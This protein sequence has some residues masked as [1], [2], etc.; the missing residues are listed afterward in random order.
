MWPPCGYIKYMRKLSGEKRTAIL[1][2]LVEG[3]SI[4]ATARMCGVSKLTILRLLADVGSLCR[5]LH[6]VMVRGLRSKRIQADEIWAFCG[7]KQK[8]KESGK[9]GHGDVW[10]WI[11]MDAETKIVVAYLVGKRDAACANDFML[12]V[13]GRVLQHLQLTTDGH[14]TYLNAVENA[15]G[16]EVDYAQLVKMYGS[17]SGPEGPER[18]Y[19][20][21]QCNGARK[22]PQLGLPEAKH[23]STSYVERQNLTVRMGNRRHTRLTNAFSKKLSNHEHAIALHYFHYNFIRRHKTL[24]TTPAVASGISNREWTIA[25][26]VGLLEAE[27][28]ENHG[29]GRINRADRT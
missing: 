7:C 21:G 15:F 25:D 28:R 1:A 10:T 26:L 13:A 8:N 2:A 6:N 4:N 5:K 11:A 19:S 12:D 24:G 18:K 27:E 14:K 22:V 16:S 29:H 20:P 17:E 3:S 9:K 23:I